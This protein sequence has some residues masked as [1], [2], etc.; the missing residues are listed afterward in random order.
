MGKEYG[1]CEKCLEKLEAVY[2]IEEE[3]QVIN[4]NL[5]KTGRKRRAVDYL[6]CPDCLARYC[7]DDTFD[8]PWWRD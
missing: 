1:L 6:I 4:G 7:V 2:F 3:Y 8:E 5:I